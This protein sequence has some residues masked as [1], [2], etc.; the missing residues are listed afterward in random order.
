MSKHERFRVVIAGGGVAALEAMVALRVLA[1]ERV[2]MTLLAP[3][4][5]FVYRPLAVAEPFGL[6]RIARFPLRA[7]AAG[8]GA[9][10]EQGALMLVTPDAR[11]IYTSRSR[12]L[13]YDAL[14]V[15][16]GARVGEGVEGAV[17]FGG[18]DDLRAVDMLLEDLDKGIVRSVVFAVPTGVGWT[19][20]LYELALLTAERVARAGL[21]AELTLVTPEESPLGVFGP[22]ASAKIS[23]LLRERGV[24][25]RSSLHAQAFAD[26]RLGV[27]EGDPIP[28]DWALTLPRLTGRVIDGIPHDKDGFVPTDG[29]GRVAGVPS[30][31]AAGDMTAFPIKQGGIAAQQADAAAEAIAAA[32][33]ADVVPKPFKPVLRGLLLTGGRPTFLRT[34]IGRHNEEQSTVNEEPLW[35][36]AGKIAARYLGP[37]LAEQAR[38]PE[39]SRYEPSRLLL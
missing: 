1:E 37:Y 5:I 36:P 39:S 33:G 27:V 6:G 8:C 14:L 11:S 23:T 2:E 34:E 18:P 35:W 3:D 10:Y 19:L 24:V 21:D 4:E 28:A 30:V 7:L 17:T 29:L 16:A 38:S 15:A 26:G 9:T 13:E 20:P 32:A 22:E 31:Y 25:V 12:T